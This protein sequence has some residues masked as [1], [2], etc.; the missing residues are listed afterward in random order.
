MRLAVQVHGKWSDLHDLSAQNQPQDSLVLFPLVLCIPWGK[1]AFQLKLF[2]FFLYFI[3][4]KNLFW[5]TGWSVTGRNIL[6]R[7]NKQSV[8]LGY[9][10]SNEMS[11]CLFT[12]IRLL[13]IES[14]GCVKKP[15]SP[16]NSYFAVS[17]TSC[18]A[19]QNF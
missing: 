18:L 19:T 13:W 10:L 6:I 1:K 17:K 2:F 15:R 9:S 5:V 3:I 14:K 4:S 11:F 12:I 16:I 7:I 8:C